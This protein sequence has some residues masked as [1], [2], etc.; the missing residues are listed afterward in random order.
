MVN[1]AGIHRRP[2]YFEKMEAE[3]AA[4]R[5]TGVMAIVVEQKVRLPDGKE[6]SDTDIAQSALNA[7]PGT[8]WFPVIRPG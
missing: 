5:V 7:L 1:D 3:H 2:N 6:R 8:S 4:G